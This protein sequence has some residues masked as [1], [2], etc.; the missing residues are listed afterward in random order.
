MLNNLD[1]HLILDAFLALCLMEG[2][3]KPFASYIGSQVYQRVDALTGDRLP[4]IPHTITITD[5]TDH[6]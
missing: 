1:L 5:H 2:V 4:N 3:V 6:E